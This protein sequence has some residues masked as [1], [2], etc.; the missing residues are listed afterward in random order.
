M[1]RRRIGDLTVFPIGLGCM[2][3]PGRR[4]VDQRDRAIRTIHAT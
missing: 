4:M 1:Q 2:Q 3:L